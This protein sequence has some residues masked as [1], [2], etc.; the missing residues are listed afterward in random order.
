[1]SCSNAVTVPDDGD[2]EDILETLGDSADEVAGYLFGKG[3]RGTPKQCEDCPVNDYL[4]A[5]YVGVW[6]K[7][8]A[9][10]VTVGTN[11]VVHV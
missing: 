9:S 2:I 10:K 3:A 1:M 11:L 7:T 5:I 8:D 6:F 4:E